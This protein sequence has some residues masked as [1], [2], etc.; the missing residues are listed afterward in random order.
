VDC[1]GGDALVLAVLDLAKE[2]SQLRMRK[3][4]DLGRAPCAV[5]GARVNG[6]EMNRLETISKGRRLLLTMDGQR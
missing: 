3:T 1:L 6:V 5:Q 2:R 4:S